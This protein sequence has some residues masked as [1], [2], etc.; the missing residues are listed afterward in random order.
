M[1]LLVVDI[2]KELSS[3]Q[4]AEGARP[5]RGRGGLDND[6]RRAVVALL[7]KKGQRKDLVTSENGVR[8]DEG[9]ASG[10]GLAFLFS[11]NL[12]QTAW[13]TYTGKEGRSKPLG[14]PYS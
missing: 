7:K 14:G 9:L 11:E 6:L 2:P 4:R 12:N 1:K 3:V 10:L 13:P 8:V 5:V